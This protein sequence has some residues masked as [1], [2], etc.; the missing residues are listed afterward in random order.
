MRHFD[1][2]PTVPQAFNTW[3]DQSERSL[4]EISRILAMSI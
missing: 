3:I 4:T 1:E 2:T